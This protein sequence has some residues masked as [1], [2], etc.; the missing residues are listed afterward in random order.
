VKDGSGPTS[1]GPREG[2]IVDIRPF[3]ASDET[4]I[5]DLWKRSDLVRPWNDPHK[6]IQ[7]KLRVQPELFLVG[8]LD[9]AV[10]ATVMAGYEGHRGWINYLAVHPDHQRGGLGRRLMEFA[11]QRLRSLG[12]PKINLQVRSSN[13][14]VIEFYRS[15]GFEV[16]DRV[17][18]SKRLDG[19][20]VE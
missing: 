4:A 9:D 1:S 7:R 10:S 17:S 3:Q 13:Q 20:P 14:P 11:E 2:A 5:V 16:E 8:L 6:D 18:L 12:C 15:L 19:R